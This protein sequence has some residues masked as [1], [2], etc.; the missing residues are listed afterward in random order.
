[1]SMRKQ[2]EPVLENVASR[3]AKDEIDVTSRGCAIARH[4][5][6]TS[7]MDVARHLRRF[8]KAR[9]EQ[10]QHD[11]LKI[12]FKY[13][14]YGRQ[15]RF[16]IKNGIDRLDIW[17]DGAREAIEV[18]T[19]VDVTVA[20]VKGKASLILALR[21]KRHRR[22]DRAWIAFFYK[23]KGGASPKPACKYLLCWI[24]IDISGIVNAHELNQD[25]TMI[26]HESKIA[27][28]KRISVDDNII[29]P[30]DNIMLVEE[31]E[32]ESKEKDD[33]LDAKDAIIAEKDEIITKKDKTIAELKKRLGME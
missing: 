15:G 13:Y 31:L 33:M 24:D 14:R 16:E 26:M 32:R 4:Y 7:V 8:T 27:V 2:W 22:V 21:K 18:K 30:V 3:L 23:F 17:I 11:V 20:K 1:M 28:A 12:L 9:D 6:C 5:Y 19:I 25:L 29:I 10:G